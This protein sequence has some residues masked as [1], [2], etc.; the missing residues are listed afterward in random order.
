MF[1]E[2]FNQLLQQFSP[3]APREKMDTINS[4]HKNM[5]RVWSN[6][7][8]PKDRHDHKVAMDPYALA[9]L[10]A[11]MYSLPQRVMQDGVALVLRL[12]KCIDTDSAETIYTATTLSFELQSV[13]KIGFGKKRGAEAVEEYIR[14]LNATLEEHRLPYHLTLNADEM[15]CTLNSTESTPPK[16]LSF[17]Y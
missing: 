4:Y 9:E 5:A 13:S 12:G 15:W 8:E 6:L 3:S 1:T 7:Q 2:V 14:Q 11:R 10:S 17:Q 16:Y